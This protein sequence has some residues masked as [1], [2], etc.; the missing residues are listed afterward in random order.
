MF[1]IE[2]GA[3]NKI[4]RTV[5]DKVIH[6][7]KKLKKTVKEMLETMLAPDPKTKVVGIGLAA[8]QVGILKR[9][10]I[11]SFNVNTN[12]ELKT[13][14][15]INPE[16]LDISDQTC[17]LEEGC[18]SL[19]EKFEKVRRPSKV[20]IRWQNLEGKWAEKKLDKWD[21]RVFLHE[22]DHL[23]GKLFIDYL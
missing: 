14:I 7:D 18:L 19:P 1:K 17:V 3:D 15:M 5:A 16:I 8:P 12:K 20:K 11:V 13:V 4:L 2:T 21:A 6:F 10:I 23:E 22:Y 9:I